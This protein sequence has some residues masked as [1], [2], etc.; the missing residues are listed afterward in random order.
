V[1]PPK[2]FPTLQV[3]LSNSCRRLVTCRLGVASAKRTPSLFGHGDADADADGRTYTRA[4][5]ACGD[6]ILCLKRHDRPAMRYIRPTRSVIFR[7]S[8]LWW[9]MSR[10]MRHDAW[11]SEYIHM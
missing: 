11:L 3:S 5:P 2:H 9:I 1:Q 8:R 7:Y 10:L 6:C 4:S